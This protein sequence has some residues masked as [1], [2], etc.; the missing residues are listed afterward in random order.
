MGIREVGVRK[1]ILDAVEERERIDEKAVDKEK[2]IDKGIE[3]SD[4]ETYE[5]KFDGKV[6]W[7]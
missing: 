5:F 7:K 1:A 6:T 4:I 3:V 2:D